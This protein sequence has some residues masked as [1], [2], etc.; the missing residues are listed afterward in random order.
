[1]NISQT[2]HKF[3]DGGVDYTFV[4][5]GNE[6]GGDVLVEEES[7]DLSYEI[8]FNSISLRADDRGTEMGL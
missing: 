2:R 4:V 6:I 8:S 1:M 5:P 7:R 3:C